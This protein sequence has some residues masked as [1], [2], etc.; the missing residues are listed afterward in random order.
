MRKRLLIL[1]GTSISRQIVYAARDLSMEIFVTDYYPDSP[2]KKLADKSFMVS[3]TDVDAV[4]ALIKKERIDGVIMGYA[5]VLLPYYVL[6]C[7]KAGLPCYA[8]MHA[9]EVTS[10]KSHF[11][12]LCKQ[13]DVPV[14]PEYS[15]EDV[16]VGKIEYPI[17]VK[18]VDNSGARGIFIC[19][20][21]EEFDKY[22]P[23]SMQYSPSQHVIIER[24]MNCPE[25]TIFYYFHHGEIYLLGVGDRHMWK[26]NEDLLQLPIGYTFPSKKIDVFLRNE[27][28]KLMNMFHS[29]EMNEGMAFVQA[30]IDKDH[31]VVYEMGYRFTGSLEHHLMEHAIGFNHLKEILN[32]AVGNE[33]KDSIIKMDNIN[34]SILANVTLLLSEGTIGHY[35]GLENCRLIPGVL[36]IH[37]SY[38]PGTV[39][40]DNKLGKLSQVGIR[41]LL[42]ADTRE[43]MLDLMDE[44]KNTLHIISIDG[45]ELLIKDY[46]Y[47]EVCV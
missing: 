42:S 12:E 27:N 28:E 18:P 25:S 26:H 41:V 23:E 17:I 6:I 20:N 15:F 13:F 3:C 14:V 1:G 39:I 44:V 5:D 32:Y 11:K 7:T 16:L 21:K 9:I 37:E 34:N 30:F 40:D 38:Q 8:N 2:C 35:E 19:H 43:Q 24:Y 22:Y 10:D 46:S 33:V 4:V 36:H 45:K 29:L 31:F 47:K